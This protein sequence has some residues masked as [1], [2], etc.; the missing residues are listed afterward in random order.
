MRFFSDLFPRPM[1]TPGKIYK[2]RPVFIYNSEERRGRGARER[3]GGCLLVMGAGGKLTQRRCREASERWGPP[4]ACVGL[5]LTPLTI[6]HTRTHTCASFSSSHGFVFSVLFGG[7]FMPFLCDGER[8]FTCVRFVCVYANA[9]AG[10]VLSIIILTK[11]LLTHFF[12]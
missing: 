4:R 6:P 11:L 3:D 7:L 9:F 1:H 2:R 8:V 12:G 5:T 10:W